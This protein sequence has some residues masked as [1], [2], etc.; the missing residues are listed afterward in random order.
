MAD[1]D[2]HLHWWQITFRKQLFVLTGCSFTL[3][4][5]KFL[6]E[7]AKNIL[8]QDFHFELNYFF[9]EIFFL[10]PVYNLSY[11]GLSC[12]NRYLFICFGSN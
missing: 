2:I 9:I 7:I 12:S 6:L 5:R 3:E 4:P 11:K 8:H 1:T 10:H